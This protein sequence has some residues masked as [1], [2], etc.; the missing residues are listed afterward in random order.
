MWLLTVRFFVVLFQGIYSVL[1][2]FYFYCLSAYHLSYSKYMS[3]ASG[4]SWPLSSCVS[5]LCLN[6]DSICE[7][8]L[9]NLNHDFITLLPLNCLMLTNRSYRRKILAVIKPGSDHKRSAISFTTCRTTCRDKYTSRYLTGGPRKSSSWNGCCYG[10]TSSTRAWP[11][12]QLPSFACCCEV[13]WR[14]AGFSSS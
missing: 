1:P 9:F 13:F 7:K 10:R 4:L 8:I 2:T 14:A 3:N 12:A 6:R 11:I 5:I